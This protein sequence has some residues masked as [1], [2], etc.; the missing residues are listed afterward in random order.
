MPFESSPVL[1]SGIVREPEGV[2]GSYVDA[3]P[4]RRV[5]VGNGFGR[6]KGEICGGGGMCCGLI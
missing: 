2:E 5:T 3:G 4:A 6:G 1:F